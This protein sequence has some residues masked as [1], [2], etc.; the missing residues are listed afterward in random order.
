MDSLEY[1]QTAAKYKA[2]ITS[3]P[4]MEEV[5]LGVDAWA[6]WLKRAARLLAKILTDDGV[7][8]FYQTNRKYKGGLI[9]KMNIISNEFTEKGFR[10]I[11]QKIVL[12]QKPETVNFFRPT[13]TNLFAFS[14]K[15]KAGKSTADVIFAG[16]MIYKNAMGFNAVEL[17]VNYIKKNIETDT[18]FDPFCGQGS[19]L[20]IA[21]DMGYNTI[22]ID[23]MQEQCDKAKIL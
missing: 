21:N 5:G 2:I 22:G 9:D 20:K 16:K 23:I 18:I 1:L 6:E 4:D 13:Y 10:C 15:L 7:I 11:L 3:L 12:K 14:K 17:C 19:V 8:F